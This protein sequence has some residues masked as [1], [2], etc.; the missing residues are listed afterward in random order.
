MSDAEN[1][2]DVETVLL[3]DYMHLFRG[4]THNYGQHEYNF[5]KSG[6]ESGKNKTLTD[7]LITAEQYKAHLSGKMGLGV[8]PINEQG[9]CNFGVID[10]D[11]YDADLDAYIFAIEKNNFPL[12]PFRSK[13]GG[14]HIYLFLKHE[15]EAKTV[16]E[17]LQSMSSVLAI[18]L[19]VKRKLNRILEIFPKQS[20][21]GDGKIGNWINLPYYN[22]TET[23]QYAMKAGKALSLDAALSYIH[24]KQLTA[25][26]VKAF[27]RNLA[28]SDGPPCLQTISLLNIMD[29]NS[30]RNNFLFSFGVYLKKKDP[31]FWEQR[32]FEINANMLEPLEKGEL[33]S[34][35]VASLRKKDYT[36]KC[37]D[38]PCVD[39]CRKAVCKQKEYGI[40][41]EGGYFSELEFGKLYQI[42]AYEPYYEWEVKTQSASDYKLLRF[43]NEN[44]IIKQDLFLQLCMRELHVLPVKVKQAV[45]FGIVNE[46]IVHV[47]VRN[48]EQDYDTSPM[49]MLKEMFKEFLLNRAMAV[50]KDQILSKRVYR[51]ESEDRYYFRSID[52]I[53]Y[54]WTVRNFRHYGSSELHGLLRDFKAIPFRLR[55]ESNKQIRVYSISESELNAISEITHESFKAD[56]SKDGEQF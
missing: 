55:T 20:K 36:Y 49:A 41:K 14:L 8:I 9:K 46:A 35:V 32:L 44:D 42:R 13:S 10:V 30:G 37:L 53:D 31:D 48:V 43:R 45:W 5:A 56:F 25:D 40:G 12:I 16:I 15:T 4:N 1:T 18:D 54:V 19:Y 47:E 6:K 39:F 26:E 24:E 33:E 21:A 29:K 51:D 38:T 22:A 28:F 52:L 3:A 2:N 11:V 7:R 23:R 17:L 27:L 34:S 50:T